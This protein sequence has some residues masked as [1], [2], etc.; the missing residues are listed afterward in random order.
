MSPSAFQSHLTVLE[1][2]ARLYP[3][4]P[5]F[6]LPVV[7]KETSEISE[8]ATVTYVQFHQDVELYARYWTSVLSA[9]GIAPGSIVGLW[10]VSN[11][12]PA[13]DPLSPTSHRVKGSMARHILMFFTPTGSVGLVTSPKCAASAFLT[14]SGSSSCCRRLAPKLWFTNHRLVP[15]SPNARSR[16][17]QPSKP[18]NKMYQA[19]PCPRYGPTTPH[20]ISYSSFTRPGRQVVALNLSHT[21]GDCLTTS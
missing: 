19:S 4:R 6:R 14:R 16:S 2:S 12:V 18:L 10:Y 21:T 8:W 7:N 9:G 20:L 13:N 15:T 1:S 3:T 11:L 17:I 5:A